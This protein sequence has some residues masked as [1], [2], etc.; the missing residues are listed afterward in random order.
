MKKSKYAINVMDTAKSKIPQRICAKQEVMPK[1]PFSMMISGRSGSGKTNCLMNIMTRKDLYGAYFHT[2][3]V[4]SPTAGTTDDTYAALKIPEENFIKEFTGEMLENIIEARK[5][6]IKENGIE[7]VAKKSRVCLILD[8]IIAERSFLESPM[9]L[10]LFA[11]LRHYLCSIIVLVQS[12]T[13]LPR[14][15]RLNCN[16]VVIFPC[17]QSETE[18]LIKEVTPSGITKR[19]FERVLEHCTKGRYDFLYINNHAEPGRRIR[20]NLSEVINLD[21]FKVSANRYNLIKRDESL[22]NPA[23][24]EHQP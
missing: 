17:L 9:A 18:V 24:K 16:A 23:T 12:Y 5:T 4:F 14:A 7:K 2:I 8:D 1:F 19:D 15:L 13:K 10:K 21:N 22:D 6:E 3:L 20:K 11:L